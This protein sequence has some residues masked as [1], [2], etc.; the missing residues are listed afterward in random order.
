LSTLVD[1]HAAFRIRGRSLDRGPGRTDSLFDFLF[2][3]GQRIVRNVQRA[4]L[5]FGFDYAVERFYRLSPFGGLD[6]RAL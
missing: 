3:R 2:T 1:Q 6:H 5:Y 4:A